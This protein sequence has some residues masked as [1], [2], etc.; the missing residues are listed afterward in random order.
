MFDAISE[1]RRELIIVSPWLRTAAV[2]E[3][4]IA[5]L[6]RAL[7]RNKQLKLYIGYGIG[8][9]KPSPKD[10]KHHSESSALKRLSSLGKRHQGRVILKNI[11]NTHQ[12]L[13]I[14]DDDQVMITSF[15]WLSF[16]PD[17]RFGVR[18][19]TGVMLENR[20][21]VRALRESLKSAL[22]LD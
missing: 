17:P 1:A 20:E 5:K 6:D 15:N 16:N 18:R 13:V 10:P 12:K 8:G 7:K 22:G 3:E 14:V 19:E 4:L 9:Q 11:G 2:D 21:E